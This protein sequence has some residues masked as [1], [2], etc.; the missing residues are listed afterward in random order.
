MSDSFDNL[1]IP[2]DSLPKFEEVT[3]TPIASKYAI[4]AHVQYGITY[5]VLIVL[6]LSNYFFIQKEIP[7]VWWI[8][9]VLFALVAL[10]HIYK[11]MHIKTRQYGFRTHDVLFKRGVITTTTTIIPFNKIQH[12]AV[13]QGWTSRYLGLASLEFFTAGGDSSDLEIPGIALQE[14]YQ[15]RD[16][17]L[18]K[19]SSLPLVENIKIEAPENLTN[20]EL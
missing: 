12:L 4:V 3:L 18:D 14:A 6:T 2:L 10:L 5:L 11:L 15:W 9:F 17:V 13:H 7:Y 20:E 19:I 16:L 8:V 1:P